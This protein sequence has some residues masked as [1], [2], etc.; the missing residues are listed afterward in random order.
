MTG[1]VIVSHSGIHNTSPSMNTISSIPALP[2]MEKAFVFCIDFCVVVIV[3][4]SPYWTGLQCN[5]PVLIVLKKNEF[6]SVCEMNDK[7]EN[8]ECLLCIF[9]MAVCFLCWISI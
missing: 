5:R 1:L 9:M 3:N 6:V 8:K 4:V 2:K 7:K